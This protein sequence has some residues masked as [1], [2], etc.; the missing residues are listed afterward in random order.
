M[1]NGTHDVT[2]IAVDS[3]RNGDIVNKCG[4]DADGFSPKL[5]CGNNIYFYNCRAWENSDDGW[6]SF[7]Y[8]EEK[9]TQ[10]YRWTY[11]IDYTNCMCWN[12]GNPENSMGYTDYK[13][14]L[15]LD[16]KM[17]I[18][19]RI[20]AL[21]PD[22]YEDFKNSYNNHTLCGNSASEYY[23]ALDNIGTIPTY[24]DNTKT[25]ENL[26]PSVLVSSGEEKW[27]GNPTALSLAVLIHRITPKDMSRTA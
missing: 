17:P 2:F 27:G 10:P 16:E 21:Y 15:P 11:R 25:Y 3:Y 5:G 23:K 4:D 9:Q 13:N 12:N 14:N 6:D 18:A 24:N 1:T 19:I 22:K 26:K 7:D 8:P 20:K